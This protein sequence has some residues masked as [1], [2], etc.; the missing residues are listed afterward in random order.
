MSIWDEV[1]AEYGEGP[2]Y[3]PKANF[4]SY[5]GYAGGKCVGTFPTRTDANASG[6]KVVEEVFDADGYEAARQAYQERRIAAEAAWYKR[7][8]AEYPEVN[9]ATYSIIYARA[10]GEGHGAG[11]GEVEIY[12]LEYVQFAQDIIKASGA[13]A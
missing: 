9:N 6:A 10:W 7:V 1:K 8:R 12:I 5:I 13:K 3:P 4:R 2:E 11:Y